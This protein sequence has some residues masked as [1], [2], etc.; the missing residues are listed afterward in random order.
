MLPYCAGSREREEVE[1]ELSARDSVSEK[2]GC[3]DDECEVFWWW[4]GK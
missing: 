4:E 3:G 2:A 1:S